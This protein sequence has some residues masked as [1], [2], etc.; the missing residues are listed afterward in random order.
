MRSILGIAAGVLVHANAMTSGEAL[1]PP[2]NE[3]GCSAAAPATNE[4]PCDPDYELEYHSYE[5]NHGDVCRAASG[6]GEF[7]CPERC[8]NTG[9]APPYCGTNA[10]ISNPCRAPKPPPPPLAPGEILVACSGPD[11]VLERHDHDGFAH[12]DVCRDAARIAGAWSCPS[13]CV[14]TYGLEKPYCSASGGAESVPC[15]A[16]YEGHAKPYRC[17]PGGGE[18]GVCIKAEGHPHFKGAGKYYRDD[19]NGECGAAGA[20]LPGWGCTDDWASVTTLSTP[21]YPLR[22]PVNSKALIGCTD[23]PNTGGRRTPSV[24]SR[25]TVASYLIYADAWLHILTTHVNDGRTAPWLGLATKV[26]ESARATRGQ[27]GQIAVI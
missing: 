1:L 21:S 11:L 27:R 25:G 12:G 24:S 15:R 8:V 16:P 26:Q 17:D 23:H 14:P 6:T 20:A 18:R 4:E 9:G 13:M 19:C 3:E 22:F 10:N 2:V 7:Q 5:P